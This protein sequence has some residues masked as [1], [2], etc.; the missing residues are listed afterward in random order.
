MFLIAIT[1]TF[2]RKFFKL[3]Q[4][5]KDIQNGINVSSESSSSDSSDWEQDFQDDQ[6]DPDILRQ[7]ERARVLNEEIERR[8][9]ERER[10]ASGLGDGQNAEQSDASQ[11]GLNRVNLHLAS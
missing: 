4:L 10:A 1:W 8:R 9:A 6:N 5:K 7:R 2:A 3:R 11:V